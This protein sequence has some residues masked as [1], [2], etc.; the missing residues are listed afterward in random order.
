MKLYRWID[1]RERG[2]T[3]LILREIEPPQ[4]H[5]R[6]NSEIALNGVIRRMTRMRGVMH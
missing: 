6:L 5:N 2:H 3:V 4:N 1:T